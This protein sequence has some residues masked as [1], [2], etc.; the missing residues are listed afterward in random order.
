M[1]NQVVAGVKDVHLAVHLC[2]RAGLAGGGELQHS[3]ELRSDYS[4]A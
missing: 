2:R 1:T 3:G 4:A